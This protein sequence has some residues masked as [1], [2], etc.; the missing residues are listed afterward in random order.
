[1]V[2]WSCAVVDDEHLPKCLLFGELIAGKRSIG[3]LKKH[4]KDT[5]KASFKDFSIDPDMWVNLA[6]DRASWPN[7]M[8]HGAASYKSQQTSHAIMKRDAHEAKAVCAPPDSIEHLFPHCG[9]LFHTCIGLVSHL[10]S[11]QTLMAM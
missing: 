6:S 5:L 9:R 2:G 3:G 10:H 8:H 4:F 11:H 7:A 1:M